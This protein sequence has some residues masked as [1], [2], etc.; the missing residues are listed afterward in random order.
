MGGCFALEIG[1]GAAAAKFTGETALHRAAPDILVVT[2]NEDIVDRATGETGIGTHPVAFAWRRGAVRE[3]ASAVVFDAA[4][5]THIASLAI[6]AASASYTD[7]RP[8]LTS[9][10]NLGF[11]LAARLATEGLLITDQAGIA[12]VGI[13]ATD[14]RLR[15]VNADVLIVDDAAIEPTFTDASVW[16]A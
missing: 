13:G 3:G 5:L 8:G 12:A 14:A 1:A 10:A 6:R 2:P 7:I 11:D 15:Q 16:P 4:V 9:T